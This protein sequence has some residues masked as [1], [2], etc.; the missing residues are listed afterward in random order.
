MKRRSGIS[1]KVQDSSASCYYCNLHIG[2]VSCLL[3]NKI[4]CENCICD[5]SKYCIICDNENLRDSSNT[6]IKIPLGNNRFN[7]LVLEN[8]CCL[9]NL[10]KRK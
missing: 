7:F 5:K 2:S 9:W 8:K 3:C 10:F 4:V 1:S 6:Y